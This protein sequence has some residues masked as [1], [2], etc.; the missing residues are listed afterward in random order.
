VRPATNALL[1]DINVAPPGVATSDRRK[2]VA[3]WTTNVYIVFCL[4]VG[5]RDR[6][7]VNVD[8][9]AH[10]VADFEV[11]RTGVYLHIFIRNALEFV[12]NYMAMFANNFSKSFT[13]TKAKLQNRVG[14]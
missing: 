4:D 5:G 7:Q 14:K 6:R 13:P 8:A 11:P 10:V 9:V 2:G 1:R 3:G 12:S